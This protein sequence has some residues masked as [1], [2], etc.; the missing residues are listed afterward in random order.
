[1]GMLGLVLLIIVVDVVAI[2]KMSM[3]QLDSKAVYLIVGVMDLFIVV[4]Y[5]LKT[6]NLIPN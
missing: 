5:I 1:M 3:M 2:A 4:G 6:F